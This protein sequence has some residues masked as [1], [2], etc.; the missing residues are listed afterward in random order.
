M[1][2]AVAC[3]ARLR[4]LEVTEF[5]PIIDKAYSDKKAQENG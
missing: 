3:N 5:Y 4:F 1:K 2:D